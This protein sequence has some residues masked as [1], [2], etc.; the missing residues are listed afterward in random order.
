[1]R[2]TRTGIALHA[3]L[4]AAV[5]AGLSGSTAAA[6]T[7]TA[8]AQTMGTDITATASAEEPY[9]WTVKGAT[10]W[11]AFDDDE[12]VP[13]FNVTKGQ[14]MEYGERPKGINLVWAKGGVNFRFYRLAGHTAGGGAVLYGERIAIHVDDGGYLKYATRKY[15]IN[16]KWS[17]T[18][19]YEWEIRGHAALG[20][21]VNYN[22]VFGL[23]N[24]TSGKHMIYG[25]R[26]YG[27]DLLWW[28]QTPTTT[29]TVSLAERIGVP[30]GIVRCTLS[31]TWRLEPVTLTGT[32]GENTTRVFTRSY[33]T[34]PTTDEYCIDSELTGNLRV[35]TWRIQLETPLWVANCQVT[36]RAGLNSA[37]FTQ[38]RSGCTTGFDWP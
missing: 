37:H 16:I 35:G 5:F 27:I 10:S 19:V 34:T 38:Y 36:F 14:T 31:V 4:L 33:E 22:D 7:K 13:L 18:P 20:T 6:Q 15:G 3:V 2:S 28:P 29:A 11:G 26:P 1:M 30:H 32:T 17:S 24:R 25:H 23:Y 9:D 8:A 12:L 21:R